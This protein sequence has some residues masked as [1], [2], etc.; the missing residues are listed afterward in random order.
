MLQVPR[1]VPADPAREGAALPRAGG[2]PEQGPGAVLPAAA[3][4]LP[5]GARRHALPGHGAAGM[6]LHRQGR[7]RSTP[8]CALPFPRTPGRNKSIIETQV[9]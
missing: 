5:Q 3:A 8:L 2:E 9:E 1:D 7:S 4:H 6:H